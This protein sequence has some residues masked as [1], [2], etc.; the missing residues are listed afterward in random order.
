MKS[1]IAAVS[2]F[3]LLLAL[4]L[5]PATAQTLTADEII[6]RVERNTVFAT[7]RSAGSMVV[8]D[9]FGDRESTFASWSRGDD[10]TLIEFT[11][12]EER[13]MKILR[14]SDEIY[15]YYPDAAELIRLQGAALRD[16]VL[17][18]DMSYEDLTG[19]KGL[20]R[21][22]RA[23]LEGT[24]AVDGHPCYRV[25]LEALRRDVAY[26]RQVLWVDSSLFL[27]RRIHK[28][29]RSGALLKEVEVDEIRSI[30]GRNVITRM[31]LRDTLKR[32]SSTSF[33]MSRIEIDIQLPPTIFSLGELTW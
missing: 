15:L 29:A 2:A 16:A 30:A 11:S 25:S 1:L 28:F 31:T 17:G 14:T 4:A 22:Y 3:A 26:Y 13:G 5:A 18:S 23:T 6:G 21:S 9:R 19:G 7:A 12:A 24:E 27:P 8:R 32:G 10:T 20:L 33:V